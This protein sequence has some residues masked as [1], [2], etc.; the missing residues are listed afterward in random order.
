M[1]T[2]SGMITSSNLLHLS[3]E[4]PFGNIACSGKV[5][6]VRLIQPPTIALPISVTFSG[7][8]NSFKFLQLPNAVSSIVLTLEGII[9][10]DIPQ[11]P[12]ALLPI[13]S[14]VSGSTILERLSHL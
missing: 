14:K 12:N 10:S 4:N 11:K 5:I 9:N 2:V 13:F 6:D 3:T 7:I 8:T 1:V